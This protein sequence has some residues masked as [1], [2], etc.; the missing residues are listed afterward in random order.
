MKTFLKFL[1]AEDGV[2][3]MEYALVGGLIVIVAVAAMAT[4]GPKLK[5]FYEDLSALI[6]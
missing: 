2:E 1:T 3:T 4:I 6:P 5:A